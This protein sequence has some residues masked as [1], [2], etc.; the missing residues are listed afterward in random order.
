MRIKFF[1]SSGETFAAEAPDGSDAE[2]RALPRDADRFAFWR[3][4][5]GDSRIQGHAMVWEPV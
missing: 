5:T 2:C 1:V 3:G 4:K